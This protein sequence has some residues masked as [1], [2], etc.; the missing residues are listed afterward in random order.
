MKEER[1]QC[2]SKESG[3]LQ[4]VFNLEASRGSLSSARCRS[5]KQ[6]ENLR[7]PMTL[8]RLFSFRDT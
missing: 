4:V 2:E 7:Y 6:F 1:R 8:C 3:P 5:P